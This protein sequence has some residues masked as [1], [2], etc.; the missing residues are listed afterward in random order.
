M[1]FCTP[2]TSLLILG[3]AHVPREGLDLSIKISRFVVAW[4]QNKGCRARRKFSPGRLARA[5]WTVRGVFAAQTQT[6]P[7]RR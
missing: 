2:R 1:Q 3:I 4:W 6:P 5:Q 7:M